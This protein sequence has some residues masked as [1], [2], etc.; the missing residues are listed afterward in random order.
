MQSRHSSTWSA[1][2]LDICCQC[3]GSVSPLPVA[4]VQLAC[5][6][7]SPA[8]A[9]LAPV[10]PAW[11]CC[12]STARATLAYTRSSDRTSQLNRC[13]GTTT[14]GRQGACK[15]PCYCC[16]VYGH[17]CCLAGKTRAPQ[18]CHSPAFL[19]SCQPHSQPAPTMKVHQRCFQCLGIFAL[20]CHAAQP[21]R[22]RMKHDHS[23][24]LL[25][26]EELIELHEQC[27]A[28]IRMSSRSM[29]SLTP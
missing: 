6:Q 18:S 7:H 22:Q 27:D 3:G 20:R 24:L 13:N 28:S 23:I 19:N 14:H 17:M 12:A 5:R 9:W 29:T 26:D 4:A 1:E 11:H 10:Q 25:F 21:I 8:I 15:A 2:A 16:Q